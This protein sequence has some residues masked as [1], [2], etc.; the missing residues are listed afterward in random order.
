MTGKVWRTRKLFSIGITRSIR[1][2]TREFS[3]RWG[4]HV[5]CP[6]LMT[7]L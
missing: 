4:R 6:S 1:P 5:M 2:N 3:P 7:E